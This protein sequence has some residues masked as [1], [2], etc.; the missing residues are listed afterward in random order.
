MKS[1]KIPPGIL[2]WFDPKLIAGRIPGQHSNMHYDHERLYHG[3]AAIPPR[4]SE[5]I[6]G[7]N[8]AQKNIHTARIWRV[9]T[10]HVFQLSQ[11]LDQ[12]MSDD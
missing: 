7:K 10:A 11:E 8:D 4:D 6:P 12:T 1:A 9:K 3:P 2:N 5:L